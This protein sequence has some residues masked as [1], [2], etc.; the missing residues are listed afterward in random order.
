[1]L[2]RVLIADSDS[3]FAQ[4]LHEAFSLKGYVCT[5]VGDG[6][7]AIDCL[8]KG[9]YSLCVLDLDLPEKDGLE[10]VEFIKSEN[11]S[12]S[13]LFCS[14]RGDKKYRLHGLR[15]GAED[16]LIKPIELE[17]LLIKVDRVK[18]RRE[19]IPLKKMKKEFSFGNFKF[20]YD[21]KQLKYYNSISQEI[22]VQNLTTKD[23]ELLRILAE[24]MNIVVTRENIL[25]TIWKEDDYLNARSLDV[26]I[27]R[28]RR[29]LSKDESVKIITQHGVGFRLSF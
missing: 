18:F 12:T 7:T 13:F 6:K 3:E 28:L 16:Y 25:H 2:F 29:Y 5:V 20:D 15:L 1:M 19:N 9:D 8:N 11:L 26:Y 17:E 14:F 21:T 23:N 24:N 4:L 10:V 27:T 22:E